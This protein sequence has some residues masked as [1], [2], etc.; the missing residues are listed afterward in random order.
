MS[1]CFDRSSA[2]PVALCPS[3]AHTCPHPRRACSRPPSSG[4][5]LTCQHGHGR[6]DIAAQAHWDHG[7]PVHHFVRLIRHRCKRAQAEGRHAHRQATRRPCDR[8]CRNSGRHAAALLVL[9]GCQQRPPGRLRQHCC[10]GIGAGRCNGVQA[11]AAAAV[12]VA[13]AH[14]TWLLIIV[15]TCLRATVR[16]DRR[17][18]VLLQTE[19]NSCRADPAPYELRRAVKVEGQA[20]DL[21]V[22]RKTAWVEAGREAQQQHASCRS[23]ASAFRRHNSSR[24]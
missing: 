9:L 23:L 2:A 5:A 4:P 6:P 18:W 14:L 10:C 16:T 13:A 7:C 17:A 11:A 1:P 19:R 3:T 8:R 20:S 12:A 15:Y 22:E 24:L 21:F